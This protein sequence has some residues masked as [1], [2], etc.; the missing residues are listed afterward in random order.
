M[1]HYAGKLSMHVIDAHAHVHGL[2][3]RASIVWLV[4]YLSQRMQFGLRQCHSHRAFAVQRGNG[5]RERDKGDLR[6][7]IVLVQSDDRIERS[8]YWTLEREEIN[9][10]L[11]QR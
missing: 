1:K 2:H 11:I 8:E 6:D 5:D 10:V 4:I 7:V 9:R 3:G